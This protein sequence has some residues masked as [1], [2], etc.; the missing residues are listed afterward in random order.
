MDWD[1]ASAEFKKMQAEWKTVGPV[2]RNKSEAVWNRFRAA[3]DKFFERY[4]NRHQLALLGKLAEREAMVVE[5]ESLAANDE[6]APDL[7]SRVQTLRTTWN[8]AVPIPVAEAKTLADRWQTALM[9]LAQTR[10][11]LFKG[12]E[13][14]AA[15][16]IQRLEKLAAKIEAHLEDEG[17]EEE[18]LSP[19]EALAARLR[20]ALAS[21][22]MGGR[23]S[24]ESKWRAAAEQVKEAQ[25]AWARLAPLASPDRALEARFKDACRRVNEHAKRTGGGSH[26]RPAASSTPQHKRPPRPL[27]MA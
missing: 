24:N 20:N 26:A 19:T 12:T 2:R 9:K 17:D 13:L 4:H 1:A 18:E 14:D 8:R 22:A 5:L 11:D 6:A 7:A 10:A 16:A 23:A 21:N 27:A 3:A 25:A 15:A